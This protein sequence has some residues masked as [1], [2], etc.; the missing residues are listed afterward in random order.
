MNRD[1]IEQALRVYLVADPDHSRHDIVDG[2]AAAI[3]GGV[4]MVQLRAKHLSDREFV[5]LARTLRS[6]CHAHSVPF[7]VNDRID[8]ALA[9][10][11]DGVHLGVDDLPLEIARGLM[12]PNA[13]IGYSPEADDQCVAA[14]PL[15]ADY[16]GIGPIYGTS[17][18]EDAGEA[19]G[20]DAVGRR[21]S[22]SGLP[23]IGIGG[24]NAENAAKVISAGG[25]G[26]AVVN[27][28][29]GQDDPKNAAE[30][31]VTAVREAYARRDG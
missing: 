14:G 25:Y 23:V 3:A 17:A 8:V 16:L 20:V 31:L 11:A 27:A 10:V 4:S 19:I 6:L 5:E 2:T 13:I 12:G 29:L 9:V 30:R 28:I 15:G 24:I 22:L 1:E 26:V 18:K 21:A 7:I